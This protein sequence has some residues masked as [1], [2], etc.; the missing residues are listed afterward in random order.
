VRNRNI[1]LIVAFD[2]AAYRGWQVQPDARTVQGTLSEAI[3][4]ITG[5]TVILTGSG[6][7]DSGAHARGLV[8]NFHTTAGI[9]AP[10]LAK[11]LNS[12]LPRD[13]RVLSAR[14]VTADFHARHDARSK[15]YRYQVYRGIVLPPH[16]LSEHYHYRYRVDLGPMRE[17]MRMIEGEHDFA[18][19]A[20][21]SGRLDGM[22]QGEARNTVRRIFRSELRTSG[23]RLLFTFEGSGFLHHM[24]R[25]L[26]GTVLEVGRGRLKPV[27]FS[28][29]FDRR[30]RTLAGATAPAHG[31]IL[32]RV[33]YDRKR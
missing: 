17:A 14:P 30:D 29:L 21:K 20:A 25:N 9:P 11:A 22:V 28:E 33:R 27:E 5:E 2:G 13:I 19:F 24:V 10:R 23:L 1:K 16:L 4:N 7:T 26:V 8:A 6:R 12:V 32:M 31:L 3:E 18:S 15:I